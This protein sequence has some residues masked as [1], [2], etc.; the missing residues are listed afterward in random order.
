MCDIAPVTH[1]QIQP[2]G[3]QVADFSPRHA[4]FLQKRPDEEQR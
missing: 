4:V 3:G 1:R 2:R